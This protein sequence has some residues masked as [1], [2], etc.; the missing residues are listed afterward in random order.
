MSHQMTCPVCRGVAERIPNLPNDPEGSESYRCKRCSTRA[1]GEDWKRQLEETFAALKL[2][3]C[4]KC[5]RPLGEFDLRCQHCEMQ[6][7]DVER[8][9]G[10]FV[11]ILGCYVEAL[12]RQVEL[13]EEM[14][15]EALH[16]LASWHGA[17]LALA[18]GEA[19]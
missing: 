6:A 4:R 3:D 5:G 2:P 16:D 14:V 19:S 9:Q 7:L 18:L 12:A 10:M 17:P 11:E 13:P 15:A 8:R 1:A